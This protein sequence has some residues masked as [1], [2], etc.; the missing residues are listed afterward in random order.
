MAATPSPQES[1]DTLTAMVNQTL[2]ETGRFFR[3]SGSVRSRAQLKKNIPAAHDQFQSALDNLSEQIVR[4]IP[5]FLLIFSLLTSSSQFI[6]KAFLEKDYHAVLQKKAALRPKPPQEDAHMKEVVSPNTQPATADATTLPPGSA[7]TQNQGVS[8]TIDQPPAPQPDHPTL[9]NL[10]PDASTATNQP[11]PQHADEVINFDSLFPP[12]SAT[13]NLDIAMAFSTDESANQAFLAGTG[14][15][16]MSAASG[17][18]QDIENKEM[19]RPLGALLPGLESYASATGDEFNLNLQLE[20][21]NN[22]NNNNNSTGQ[23]GESNANNNGNTNTSTALP[24]TGTDN[25]GHDINMDM[26]MDGLQT[27]SNF[28]DMFIGVGGFGGDGAGDGVGLLN[29]VEIGDLD[30]SWF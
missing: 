28:D 10:L 12:D 17:G 9:N 22:N 19:N 18:G 1:L 26:G 5:P 23:K 11:Q 21:N 24:D 4:P 3:A 15:F 14:H 13:N 6:A 25:A 29:D 27:E 20:N 2:I 30:D 8:T 7:T 16:D